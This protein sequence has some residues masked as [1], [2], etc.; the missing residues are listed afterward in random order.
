MPPV[1]LGVRIRDRLM[2]FRI[3][4]DHV[5]RYIHAAHTYR[6]HMVHLPALGIVNSVSI[7][8]LGPDAGIPRYICSADVRCIRVFTRGNK[9]LEIVSIAHED[10]VLNTREAA[11]VSIERAAVALGRT[12]IDKCSARSDVDGSL[13]DRRHAR[14][15]LFR[16]KVPVMEQRIGTR[17]GKSHAGFNGIDG[18][19]N[20]AC[21]SASRNPPGLAEFPLGN[22]RTAFNQ[23]SSRAAYA[24]DDAL[25]GPLATSPKKSRASEN[26]LSSD[27]DL[28]KGVSSKAIFLL[29]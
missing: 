2:I 19:G 3:N 17:S 7:Q 11:G 16:Q 20:D 9:R 22:M 4:E 15:V 26:R 10:A 6:L 28:I 14:F 23:I 29:Q 8:K 12:V 27:V 13:T 18:S 21:C 5:L 25:S 24:A 1:I